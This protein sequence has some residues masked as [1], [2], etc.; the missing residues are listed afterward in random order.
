[1]MRLFRD[2]ALGRRE[3]ERRE[4]EEIS[5]AYYRRAYLK[6]LCIRLGMPAPRPVEEELA[7]INCLHAI[8]DRIDGMPPRAPMPMPPDL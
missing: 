7:L 5:A 6:D 3:R 8:C 2:A 1:M 4:A